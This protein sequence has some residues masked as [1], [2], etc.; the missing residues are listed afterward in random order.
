MLTRS[1]ISTLAD[2]IG[3]E[4]VLNDVGSAKTITTETTQLIRLAPYK[5]LAAGLT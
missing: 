5:M 1:V 2:T 3:K 4:V